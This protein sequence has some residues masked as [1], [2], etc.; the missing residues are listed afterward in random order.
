MITPTSLTDLGVFDAAALASIASEPR[1]FLVENLLFEGSVNI[2]VGDSGLGKTALLLSLGVAVASGNPFLGRQVA[3]GPVLFVDGESPATEFSQM[4]T[5]LSFEAGLTAPPEDFYVYNPQWPRQAA[6]ITGDIDVDL[7]KQIE[8][9]KPKL[10]IIDPL[11][12]F[13]P[14]A[15]SNAE[16]TMRMIHLLRELAG[17]YGVAFLVLH[18]RRKRNV[19]NKVSVEDDV[20]AWLQEAAGSRA[21]IN[22]TDTRLAIDKGKQTDLV[23]GGFTRILGPLTPI[24]IIR[25][26]DDDGQPVGYR[27][28]AGLEHLTPAQQ[29]AYAALP[30][31]FRYTD[32][33]NVLG[34][35]SDR[36]ATEFLN[37]GIT[38]GVLRAEGQ[39][40]KKRFFKTIKG[41][42]D[43]VDAVH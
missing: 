18:H 17:T 40:K 11:R 33:K 30:E 37:A 26:H 41:V 36:A 27:T 1:E 12:I 31:S 39:R 43:H 42:G 16:D 24:H 2:A 4:L 15:E 25:V 38:F 20:D 22:Q 10:V 9:I 7:R 13:F 21:L 23:V 34:G 35:N 8:L 5:A 19:N 3:Q 6:G 28:L 32:A 14:S 29:A